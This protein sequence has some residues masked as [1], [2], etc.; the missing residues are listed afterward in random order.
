MTKVFVVDACVGRAAGGPDATFPTSKH[1]RDF[2]LLLQEARHRVAFDPATHA[3]WKAHRSRFAYTWLTAMHARR[4]V[5]LADQETSDA[6]RA[7]LA[8][9]KGLADHHRAAIEKDANIVGTALAHDKLLASIDR[10]LL[11]ALLL[12]CQSLACVQGLLWIDVTRYCGELGAWIRKG[13]PKTKLPVVA[14]PAEAPVTA[15]R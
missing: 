6:V 5:I 2:L 13:A 7:P 1:S 8:V 10:R 9:T 12:A 14:E 15:V 4:L 11:D 3:E